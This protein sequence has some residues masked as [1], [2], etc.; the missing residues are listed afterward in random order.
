M[1]FH[2]DVLMEKGKLYAYTEQKLR[3]DMFSIIEVLP[4]TDGIT[5]ESIRSHP[6]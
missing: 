3:F 5:R 6:F 4:R 2:Q 1:G